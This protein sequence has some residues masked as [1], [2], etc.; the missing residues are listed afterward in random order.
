MKRRRG[1]WTFISWTTRS[2]ILPCDLTMVVYGQERAR[3][4]ERTLFLS[5]LEANFSGS[6]KAGETRSGFGF[7][8]G[9]FPPS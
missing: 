1:K 7:W 9:G 4:M 5:S 2:K 8:G 6:R 3:G